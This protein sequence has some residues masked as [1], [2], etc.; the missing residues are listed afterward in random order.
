MYPKL[1]MPWLK[2]LSCCAINH[3]G[4]NNIA[5]IIICFITLFFFN[6]STF[7]ESVELQNYIFF[8]YTQYLNKNYSLMFHFFL[9]INICIHA[10][11]SFFAFLLSILQ[12]YLYCKRADNQKKYMQLFLFCFRL[13][14]PSTSDL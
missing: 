2:W 1:N 7:I 13:A 10:F 11:N 12:E 14:L 9:I 5:T 8:I 3:I 4:H 6:L